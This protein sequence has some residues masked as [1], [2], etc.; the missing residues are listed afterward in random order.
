M[1]VNRIIDFQRNG[2]NNGMNKSETTFYFK[3]NMTMQ[4]LQV[5]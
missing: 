4:Q 1:R 2:I 5:I 3:K